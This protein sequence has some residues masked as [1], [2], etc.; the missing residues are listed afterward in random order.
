VLTPVAQGY[1]A[2]SA[3]QNRILVATGNGSTSELVVIDSSTDTIANVSSLGAFFVG[4]VAVEPTGVRAYVLTTPGG[5]TVA[6]SAR[7]VEIASGAVLAVVQTGPIPRAFGG[8]FIGGNA[9]PSAVAVPAVSV[10]VTFATIASLAMIAVLR[11]AP[12]KSRTH[13]DA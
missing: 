7:V 11:L 5:T 6:G 12:K 1:V 10:G 13:R 9:A 3:T 4:D 2:A 8:A